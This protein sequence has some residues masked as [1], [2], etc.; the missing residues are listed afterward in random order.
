M[1][2]WGTNKTGSNR[3]RNVHRTGT[4]NSG[5]IY[6][7]KKLI[8]K[9]SSATNLKKN[10]LLL[11]CSLL[12]RPGDEVDAGPWRGE[13]P[14]VVVERPHLPLQRLHHLRLEFCK[15]N[16]IGQSL[17][18][19]EAFTCQGLHK[20]KRRITS[21]G[22]VLA[23][24]RVDGIGDVFGGRDGSPTRRRDGRPRRG[25]HRAGSSRMRPLRL[26]IWGNGESATEAWSLGPPTLHSV[27]PTLVIL[28][29]RL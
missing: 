18:L 10:P 29:G 11:L 4:L 16:P 17:W 2:Q 5:H 24:E 28:L 21:H 1:P 13:H 25:A 20:G 6:R 8:R 3:I 15:A 7:L 19:S 26:P 12:T 9:P 14:A 23:V 22:L 27:G